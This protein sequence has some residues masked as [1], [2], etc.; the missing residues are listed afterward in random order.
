MAST[1]RYLLMKRRLQLWLCWALC[2]GTWGSRDWHPTSS[3][4]W[5]KWPLNQVLSPQEPPAYGK[6]VMGAASFTC[7]VPSPTRRV[8]H[9]L[10]ARLK[11]LKDLTRYGTWVPQSHPTPRRVSDPNAGAAAGLPVPQ[12]CKLPSV[13]SDRGARCPLQHTSVHC[14]LSLTFSALD[15]AGIWNLSFFWTPFWNPFLSPLQRQR[16]E[17]LCPPRLLRLAGT[18][19]VIL[20]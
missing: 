14:A 10:N 1:V 18:H 5:A 2:R 12:G 9:L 19:Q 16:H 6:G 20:P 11:K 17:T 8:S 13:L 15:S 3:L 7:P 4:F